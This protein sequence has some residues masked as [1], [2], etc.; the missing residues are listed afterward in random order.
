MMDA[1]LGRQSGLPTV[2][3]T[4]GAAVGRA[5]FERFA[6][7]RVAVVFDAGEESR[8]ERVAREL[9]VANARSAWVVPLPLPEGGDVA[10]WFVKY[11]RSRDELIE[12][13]REAR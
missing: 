9:T 8:A 13:I 4:A 12:L 6:D 11:G 7:R 1:L 2:T 3:S 5:L 10:D